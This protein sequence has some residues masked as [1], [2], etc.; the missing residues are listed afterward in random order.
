MV[1]I[2]IARRICMNSNNEEIKEQNA[3]PDKLHSLI[4][5]FR[6]NSHS[7]NAKSNSITDMHE[8][9][10]DRDSLVES[11]RLARIEWMDAS[12]NFEFAYDKEIIDYYTYQMKA[13]ETRYQYLLKMARERKIKLGKK[14]NIECIFHGRNVPG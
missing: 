13:S 14:D 8:D 5:R 10:Y 2:I 9:N 4:R 1:D 3:K 11:I 12:R 6:K 7:L